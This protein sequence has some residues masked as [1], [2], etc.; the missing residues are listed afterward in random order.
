MVRIKGPALGTAAAGQLAGS[1]TFSSSKGRAYLKKRSTPTDPKSD[2][3]RAMRAITAFLSTW[4]PDL[5]AQDRESW[6]ELAA[7]ANVTPLNAALTYNLKAW[8]NFQTPATL[9]PWTGATGGNQWSTWTVTKQGRRLIHLFASSGGGVHG[10]GWMIYRANSPVTRAWNN[11]HHV[12]VAE[13]IGQWYY[14]DGPLAPGT[15]YY[16]AHVLSRTGNIGSILS[17]GPYT[18]P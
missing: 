18:I 7:A 17:R 16:K 6:N 8:R 15:Y 1:L 13:G 3:Q 12:Q 4:W 10:R 2:P 14:H 11:L 9:Y 5:P